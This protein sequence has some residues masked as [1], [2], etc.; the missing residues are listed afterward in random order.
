MKHNITFIPSVPASQHMPFTMSVVC[1]LLLE[2]W[3]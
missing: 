2:G 3:S 1:D